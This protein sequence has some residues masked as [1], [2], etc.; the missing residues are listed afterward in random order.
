MVYLFLTDGFEEIEALTV[1]DILR[2]AQIDIKTV[3][4]TG[5]KSVKGSHD[6][7][8][9]ADILI[10]EADKDDFEMLVLP[11]G[12]GHKNLEESASLSKL[13]EKAISDNKWIAAIC[14]APSILGKKGYLANKKAVC[15]PGFEKYLKGAEVLY[16]NVMLDGKII[17]SRGAGTAIEFALEAVKALTGEKISESLSKSILFK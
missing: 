1:V 4:I 15:F 3:S 16:E 12:P 5:E 14:A 7:T 8:V 10:E 6:I 17:T 13:L 9:E 2:R 11:G